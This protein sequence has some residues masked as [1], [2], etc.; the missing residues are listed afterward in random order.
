VTRVF[1]P[2]LLAAVILTAQHPEP[3]KSPKTAA[4]ARREAAKAEKNGDLLQAYGLYAQAA[5]LDPDDQRSWALSLA[6]RRKAILAGNML[7]QVLR[8]AVAEPPPPP[9]DLLEEFRIPE[10]DLQEAREFREPVRLAPDPGPRDFDLRGDSRQVFEE[11]LKAWGID[12][13]FDADYQAVQNV[14]FRLAGV[15]FAEAIRA[16]ELATGSFVVPASERFALVARDNPNKRQ[17]LEHTVAL[18][19]PIPAPIT[20]Q[21]AQEAARTVQQVLEI[22]K[23]QVD[24][25][26]R[27]V[28]LRDRQS[29]AEPAAALFQQLLHYRPEVQI[30]LDFLE[31][32]EQRNVSY[33][34]NLPSSSSLSW[35]GKAAGFQGTL[36][37]GMLN[38]LTFGGGKTLFGF[39]VVGSQAFATMS[40]S[41]TR[42]IFRATLRSSDGQPVNFHLGDRFPI[43]TMGYFGPIEGP[44][45]VFTPPPTISFEDLGLVLK[46]TP[47]VHD[48]DEVSLAVEAEFK[49]LTGQSLNGIPVISNRQYAASARVK[50]D[51]W[52]VL[53]GL[54]SS[55]EAR[56]ITGL[57]GLSRIPAL[58]VLFRR[59]EKN[60]DD[61]QSL[62]VI[63]ARVLSTPLSEHAYLPIWTGT[64]ARPLT[65][66]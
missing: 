26:R 61:G 29:K 60:R 64:E 53:G 47:R 57:A 18:T 15:E 42:T 34:F 48:L 40:E 54:L 38:F 22:Q 5:A 55:T 12:A 35:L 43:L 58:G 14:R 49:V 8:Q 2:G 33:G 19:I 9:P 1:L 4:E 23:F 24:T 20:V 32:T 51:E 3:Y 63:K 56:I 21:E 41:Q 27:I 59:T 45:Q 66:F 50:T 25:V 6:A 46:I 30:D 17:E 39:S 37:T 10:K 13:I 62:L 36:P 11:V 16:V 44:G 52:A 28:L 31:S 7:P 65:V